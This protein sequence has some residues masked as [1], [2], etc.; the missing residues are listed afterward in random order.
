MG[1][2][3]PEIFTDICEPSQERHGGVGAPRIDCGDIRVWG[4]EAPRR[5]ESVQVGDHVGRDPRRGP[6]CVPGVPKRRPRR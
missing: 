4:F 1:W 5:R 2:N 3:E 6:S